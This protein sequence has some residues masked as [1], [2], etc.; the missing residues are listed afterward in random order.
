M[1]LNNLQQG[2]IYLGNKRISEIYIGSTKVFPYNEDII[3]LDWVKFTDGTFMPGPVS[4]VAE[5]SEGDYYTNNPDYFMRPDIRPHTV[6]IQVSM[7]VDLHKRNPNI[8]I[9]GDNL[10]VETF[11][12]CRNNYNNGE[13]RVGC[14]GSTGGKLDRIDFNSYCTDYSSFNGWEGSGYRYDQTNPYE[15]EHGFHIL[16]VDKNKLFIDGELKITCGKSGYWERVRPWCPFGGCRTIKETSMWVEGNLIYH[17]VPVKKGNK[18]G[19]YDLLSGHFFGKEDYVG[20]Y[21]N[22]I[23]WE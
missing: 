10:T 22:N 7:E 5:G 11:F 17:Y 8:P 3:F 20:G 12:G 2:Q 13:Y 23:I 9:T 6:N 14:G 21:D 16:S 1:I 4:S 18:Y 15:N 19:L